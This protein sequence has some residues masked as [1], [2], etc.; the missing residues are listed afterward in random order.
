MADNCAKY[1]EAYFAAAKLGMS[2]TP[3]NVRLGDDEIV[4]I[5]NDSEATIFIVGDGYEDHAEQIRSEAFIHRRP[6]YASIILAR[7]FPAYEELLT[8]ASEEEPDRDVYDVQ[9]DDLAILMYTGGTTGLP[10]GVMLSHRSA[11]LSGIAPALHGGL[12]KKTRLVSCCP[13]S[14]FRGGPSWRCF[15]SAGKSASTADRTSDT[16]FKLIQ[17]E[18]C[19]HLNLVPTIYG[20]MV[21]I[22]MLTSTTYPACEVLYLCRQ[23]VPR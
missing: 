5:V 22:R 15:W 2:V 23:S 6:G 3:L 8:Q 4:F 10:K 11:L 16:I 7:G 19:T 13:S 21:D 17:D 18:K 20:W 9:E 1:L 14:M 12:T